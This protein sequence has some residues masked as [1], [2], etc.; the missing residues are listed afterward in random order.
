LAAVKVPENMI[1]KL[2]EF[3]V[4]FHVAWSAKNNEVFLGF[5]FRCW[6]GMC[7]VMD[8]E[9]FSSLAAILASVTALSN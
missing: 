3:G 9:R 5:L 4:E 7:D 6:G 8:L 1:P 2:D